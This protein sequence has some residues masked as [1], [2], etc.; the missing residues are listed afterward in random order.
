MRILL[1]SSVWK[2]SIVLSVGNFRNFR[3][4]RSTYLRLYTSSSSHSIS[5]TDHSS[6]SELILNDK[7]VIVPSSK[8]KESVHSERFKSILYALEEGKNFEFNTHLPLSVYSVSPLEDLS[9]S[10]TGAIPSPLQELRAY[11]AFES[12]LLHLPTPVLISGD[13]LE[14]VSAAFLAFL[15]VTHKVHKN[16][17]HLLGVRLQINDFERNPILTNWMHTIIDH[18]YHKNPLIFRQYFEPTSSTYT[19]LLADAKT[20]EAILI[21]PVLETVDRDIQQITDLGLQLVF[22]VNTH[23]HADHITGTGQLKTKLE[24]V[25]SVISAHAGAQADIHFKEFD[26]LEFGSWRLYAIATPGH[27]EGCT[28]LVL[29]DFSR[30]FTGDTLLIRG[31]GRTDFQGGSAETLYDSVHQ[32]LFRYLPD[33]CIVYPAHDYKGVLQSTIGE[34]KTFNPRLTKP[35]ADFVHIMNTLNLPDRKSVV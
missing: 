13:S 18:Y 35:K 30:V 27:T 12:A 20:K 1:L 31:C 34:E 28:S 16:Q 22:A 21:D 5:M 14:F 23:C 9:G 17:V 4:S 33:H 26:F 15:A 11:K 2:T 25:R 6:S 10:A 24:G 29:D 8:I 7:F 19:Y 32:K 3:S